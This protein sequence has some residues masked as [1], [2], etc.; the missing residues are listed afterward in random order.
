MPV[1]S[2]NSQYCKFAPRWK[3][4]RDVLEGE[5]AVKEA[6]DDYLPTLSEQSPLEYDGYK[7]RAQFLN[8][9]GRTAEMLGGLVFRKD[10]VVK[11][12]GLDDILRDATLTGCAFYDFVK[13]VVRE[14]IGVGRFGTLIDWSEEAGRPFLVRYKAEQIINW[15]M[16]RL[17]DRMTLT[18]LTLHEM[19]PRWFPLTEKE[20]NE[21]PPDQYEQGEYDQWRVY[22]L[23]PDG[24]GARIL[25]VS[26]FRKKQEKKGKPEFVMIEQ[27]LPSRRGVSLTEIP[28]IFHNPHDAHACIDCVPLIDLAE[29]N[30]SHYRTSADL[31]NGRHFAG[32]PQ[33]YACGFE[34][35]GD[36]KVGSTVAWV[37]DN[38]AA[39]VGYLEFTGQ[40][41][42]P[43]KEALDQKEQQMVSLGASMLQPE[44][45]KAEAFQTVALRSSSDT[46]ALMNIT[47]TATQTCSNALQWV[48]WWMGTNATRAELVDTHLIELNT[49]FISQRMLAADLSALTAAYLSG[50]IDLETF[51]HNLVVG[52][53]VPAGRTFEEMR[54]SIQANPPGLPEPEP[55]E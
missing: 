51:H 40:G 26:V 17:N 33:P 15:K 10:P 28:F 18:L 50:A 2:E 42:T 27:F 41:L 25:V 29:V 22:E 14:V 55:A 44:A 6:G 38:S 3:V 45:K 19:D 20:R 5:W 54:A 31:E 16:E 53:L 30:L 11:A 21:G 24:D 52:E 43:L 39:K 13:E 47:V 37:T 7:R 4:M 1:D 9:T 34:A 36:L 48:A 49:E 32:L 23:K 46:S 35:D 12:P 8:V